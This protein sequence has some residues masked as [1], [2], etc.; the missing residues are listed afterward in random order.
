MEP[1]KRYETEMSVVCLA[2][3]QTFPAE[4]YVAFRVVSNEQMKEIGD[5]ILQCASGEKEKEMAQ[6]EDEN[7]KPCP[8]CASYHCP[9]PCPHVDLSE[10]CRKP[11]IRRSHA[12]RRLRT[13]AES[14]ALPGVRHVP[15]R[16]KAVERRGGAWKRPRDRPF[17]ADGPLLSRES[18]VASGSGE[19]SSQWPVESRRC[20]LLRLRRRSRFQLRRR[21][22]GV[23]SLRSHCLRCAAERKT[24]RI[25]ERSAREIASRN[26]SL[27]QHRVRF[28]DG[29]RHSSV[30][31]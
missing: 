19:R 14:V 22:V 18:G 15:L 11:L 4:G 26:E 28:L 25:G 5:Q 29:I 3:D 8:H 27:R 13:D 24:R 31:Q 16:K 21:S 20:A 2:C 17:Q 9:D 7:L 10:R 6:W 30:Q 23:R 12:V 1:S